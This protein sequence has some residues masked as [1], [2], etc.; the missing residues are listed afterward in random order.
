[1]T[2]TKPETKKNLRKA[3]K[4]LLVLGR[5]NTDVDTS[6][7]TESNLKGMVSS[8]TVQGKTHFLLFKDVPSA[9]KALKILRHLEDKDYLVKFVHYQVFFTCKQLEGVKVSEK[10]EHGE[11]KNQFRKFLGE[12]TNAQLLYP[13]RIYRKGEEYMGCGYLTLDTKDAVDALLSEDKLKTS[14]LENGYEVTFYRYRKTE[15]NEEGNDNEAVDA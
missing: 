9:I 14:T 7:F 6:Y 4:T 8:T 10:V 13:P 12:K 1:M 11:L 15:R 2:E 5:N 3:G